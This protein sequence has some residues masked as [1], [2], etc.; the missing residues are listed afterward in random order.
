MSPAARPAAGY[1]RR[2]RELRDGLIEFDLPRER[3][4]TRPP[5]E[6]GLGRD[7]VRLLVAHRATQRIEHR[8]F[9]HLPQL[10]DRGDVLVVNTSATLPASLAA[11]TAGGAPAELHLSTRDPDGPRERPD[12]RWIVE[13][14]HAPAAG[15]GT[16][17]RAAS[18]PWLDAAAGTVVRLPAGATARLL[19]PAA[20][21]GLAGA[22]T[23]LWIADLELPSP[24]LGYLA[25]HGRPIRYAY[26][27]RDRP[28]A[29]YQTIFARHPGSAEMPSAARPFSPELVTRLVT[30]GIVFVPVTLH[31]GVAS[32]EA[33]EPPTA[34]CYDVPAESA[35][36][37]NLARRHGRRV[38][39]VGTT[40]VRALEAATDAGLCTHAGNGWTR[41][42]ITPERGVRSIDGLITGW[43]EPHAS[44][45]A[46]LEAVA[47][48]PL[49]EASYRAAL[50]GGYL[51]HEFG[52]S[53]L[54]LS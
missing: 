1:E 9:V 8:V 4:A 37:L 36:L 39:A 21:S 50:D 18:T 12:G 14:R 28:I 42:L 49:L 38:I 54:V 25:R 30:R 45:L 35:Q 46:V 19:A 41:L 40:A 11:R 24:L 53:H 51:W 7:D 23:R 16:L 26:I 34:E 29:A 32:P 15:S 6:R 31:A 52:D 22:P 44:H 3:E 5:E 17:A 33:H 10:L 13:L 47:G 43:H 27:D 48:R 2:A 20:D